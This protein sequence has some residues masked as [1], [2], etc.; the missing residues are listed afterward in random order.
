MSCRG[1]NHRPDCNCPI[2]QGQGHS[3]SPSFFAEWASPRSKKPGMSEVA[4]R[5][6]CGAMVYPVWPRKG[7]FSVNSRERFDKHVC[8]Y[9]SPIRHPR[10]AASAA[11]K[12]GWIELA[13]FHQQ[14]TAQ[15]LLVSGFSLIEGEIRLMVLDR[16]LVSL[17]V[18]GTPVYRLLLDG[19]IEFQIAFRSEQ[20]G[21]LTGSPI[22]CERELR[23]A[24]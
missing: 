10:L 8:A 7:A 2:G 5:C 6:R 23:R 1:F 15:G 20:T 21:E 4:T 12:A 9:T 11:R 19:P 16:E 14:A 22:D 17:T 3:N 24:A 13:N 18:D